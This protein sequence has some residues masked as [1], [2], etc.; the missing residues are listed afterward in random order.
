MLFVRWLSHGMRHGLHPPRWDTRGVACVQ[1]LTHLG[2]T[3]LQ[4]VRTRNQR[5]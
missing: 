2:W 5:H 4:R 1:H 3:S